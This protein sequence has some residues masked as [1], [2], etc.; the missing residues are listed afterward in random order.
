LP[1]VAGSIGG[2]ALLKQRLYPRE[3]L[4]FA[5]FLCNLSQAVSQALESE[6]KCPLP[7]ITKVVA[8]REA[9]WRTHENKRREVV[10]LTE[11]RKTHANS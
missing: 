6:T 4:R 11:S 9:R 3:K 7:V 10:E 2:V 1:I 5:E 8:V